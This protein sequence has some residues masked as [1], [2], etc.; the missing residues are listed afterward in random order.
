M[1]DTGEP[2][3]LVFEGLNVL[4]FDQEH[5]AGLRGFDVERAGQIMDLGEINVLDVIGRVI[6][7]DLTA[8]PIETFNF[9]DL[10]VCDLSGGWD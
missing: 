9:D 7:L 2:P 10:I 4:D 1:E 6:V 5:I 3:R 8:G